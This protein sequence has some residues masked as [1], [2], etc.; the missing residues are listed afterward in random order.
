MDDAVSDLQ[1]ALQAI[2]PVMTAVTSD[3]LEKS[4]PCAGWA[5]GMVATHLLNGLN[6][7]AAA[8]VTELPPLD[9]ATTLKDVP[10][11][12]RSTKEHV[13]TAFQRPG[14]M[15]REVRGP[16]GRMVPL[17]MMLRILPVE[18][19]LHGWDIARG[20]GA[21]TDLDPE[22]A[23]QLLEVGRPMI[24]QFGRGTAFGPEQPAFPD[25]SPADRLAAFYGRRLRD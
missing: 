17:R 2:D 15:D 18:V 6:E 5:V 14:A 21:S 22:L 9:D 11:A 12:W 1:R 7:R 24:E 20:S 3:D 8:A 16:G 19:M 13:L 10:A 23:A 4:S 25:A